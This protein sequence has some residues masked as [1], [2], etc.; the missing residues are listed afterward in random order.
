MSRY[1]DVNIIKE[2]LLKYGFKAPDMTVREFVEDILP[3]ADVRKNEHGNWIIRNVEDWK[4]RP[5]GKKFCKCNKCG[6]EEMAFALNWAR[7]LILEKQKMDEVE[8]DAETLE[9]WNLDGSP[10]RYIKG[11]RMDEVEE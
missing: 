1:I 7:R 9:V 11:K 3:A 8:S 6:N 5:T 2:Q 4:G 10:T